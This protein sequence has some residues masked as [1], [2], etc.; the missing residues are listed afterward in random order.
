MKKKQWIFIVMFLSYTFIYVARLNFSM[1]GPEL[2]SKGVL[3]SVQI[4]MLGSAFSTVYALG[5]LLNG[6]ISDTTPPWKMLS[7]GL[8]VTGISNL[9]I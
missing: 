1:A 2:I 5:R 4:G 7:V 6:G 9:S 3:D 8:A